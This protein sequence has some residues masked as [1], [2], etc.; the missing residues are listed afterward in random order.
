[1]G[2]N[3][4]Q[5]FEKYGNAPIVLPNLQLCDRDGAVNSESL[6]LLHQIVLARMS[7]NIHLDQRLAQVTDC[8]EHL[9]TLDQLCLASHGHLSY[10]LS[11]LQGC[12]QQQD[13]PIDLK[14]LQQVLESDRAMRLSTI[15]DRDRQALQECLTSDHALTLEALNLCRRLLLFEHRDAFGYWFSSPF[16]TE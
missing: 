3:F 8:F 4:Q 2:T 6:N 7:L 14:T 12:L 9:E 13:P 16:A 10:L 11:L 5:L 1:M 15:S